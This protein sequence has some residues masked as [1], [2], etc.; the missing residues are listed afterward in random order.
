MCVKVGC[1]YELIGQLEIFTVIRE[2]DARAQRTP[3]ETQTA[4]RKNVPK[5]KPEKATTRR[6]RRTLAP[7]TQLHKYE[8]VSLGCRGPCRV[9]Q[10]RN[11]GTHG[12][13]TR[14]TS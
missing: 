8:V 4:C 12:G 6:S 2:R 10:T 14:M 9:A 11:A 1:F 3:R 7:H 13:A 5:P